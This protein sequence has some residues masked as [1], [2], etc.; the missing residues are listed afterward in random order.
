MLRRLQD[1]QAKTLKDDFTHYIKPGVLWWAFDHESAQKQEENAFSSRHS[2]TPKE[3]DR[4]INHP[5]S[6]VLLDEIDKANPDV[7][8]NL[9]VP[10]GSLYF[11]VDGTGTKVECNKPPLIIITTNDERDLPPAFLR[12]CVELQLSKPDLLEVG[13]AHFGE[14]HI[15][16]VNKVANLLNVAESEQ[17]IEMSSIQSSTPSPAE[18]IDTVKACI[19]LEIKPN[20][21]TWDM[22]KKVTVWKHGRTE[23]G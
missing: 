4:G 20:S 2:N 14:E 16:V 12:R 11:E 5:Q 8:N 1:A 9:L 22:L 3:Q 10:L 15:D 18:F 7:P 13:K 23:G 21:N 6:V 19:K 17:N